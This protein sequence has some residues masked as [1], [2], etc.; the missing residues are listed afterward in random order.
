[1]KVGI[2]YSSVLLQWIVHVLVVEVRVKE[3]DVL[4][5]A[6]ATRPNTLHVDATFKCASYL[7]CNTILTRTPNVHSKV[8]YS[9][10]QPIMRFAVAFYIV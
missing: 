6:R 1:M 7:V 2:Q 4:G 3:N 9:S 5:A 10:Q 8:V